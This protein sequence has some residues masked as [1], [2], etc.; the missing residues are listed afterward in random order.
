MLVAYTGMWSCTPRLPKLKSLASQGE[1]KGWT[2]D[3]KSNSDKK[4]WHTAV[5]PHSP[6]TTAKT[7]YQLQLQKPILNYNCKNQ[8]PIT[9][10]KTVPQGFLV[11][12]EGHAVLARHWPALG[13]RLRRLKLSQLHLMVSTNTP[14][15]RERAHCHAAR[16][17]TTHFRI[18]LFAVFLH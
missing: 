7:S 12:T 15:V 13:S 10:A 17:R 4:V 8:L 11:D 2:V 14:E 18:S 5:R 3:W 16:M 1:R 9:I 6:T